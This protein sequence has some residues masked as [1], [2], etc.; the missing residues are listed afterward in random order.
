MPKPTAEDLENHYNHGLYLPFNHLHCMLTIAYASFSE[1][2][3]PW[4]LVTTYKFGWITNSV[5]QRLTSFSARFP[6]T[7]A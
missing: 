5:L 7:K 3:S 2:L 1:V 6:A 4:P